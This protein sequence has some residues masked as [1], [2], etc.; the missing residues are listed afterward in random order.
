M[1]YLLALLLLLVPV[2]AIAQNDAQAFGQGIVD[3]AVSAI[4]TGNVSLYA[5]MFAS[6]YTT[7][8][9]LPP[10]IETSWETEM[11]LNFALFGTS[12][13]NPS[14]A[15]AL[16]N[17]FVNRFPTRSA[18]ISIKACRFNDVNIY[19]TV[20]FQ[21]IG[22]N[23][24]DTFSL[25]HKG[26]KSMLVFENGFWRLAGDQFSNGNNIPSP[27]QVP[28]PS[29][30]PEQS[31]N[32]VTSTVLVSIFDENSAPVTGATITDL[33]SGAM[34]TINEF[35]VATMPESSLFVIDTYATYN[36]DVTVVVMT[37]T[38]VSGAFADEINI[39]IDQSPY[40]SGSVTSPIEVSATV[41]WLDPYVN[42]NGMLWTVSS[43]YESTREEYKNVT[44][45][46]E[47]G[48]V[49]IIKQNIYDFIAGNNDW[50]LAPLYPTEFYSKQTLELFFDEESI[51]ISVGK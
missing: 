30:L 8:D 1:K 17:W 34:A 35:G 24:D 3:L 15:I 41:E 44:M 6:T 20:D 18:N 33:D 25:T 12:D 13:D 43:P 47:S 2:N 39:S 5:N 31:P 36:T 26:I 32:H 9:T 29:N 51:F 45:Y 48:I 21:I 4:L 28:N 37:Q 40:L 19:C 10:V 23:G 7:S 14:R 42:W 46:E 27:N 11:S 38:F 50:L 16:V 49:Y 22:S